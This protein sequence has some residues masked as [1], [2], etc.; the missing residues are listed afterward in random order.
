M[1]S[2]R[3]LIA[4]AA[5]A[6]AALMPSSASALPPHIIYEAEYRIDIHV[7]GSW[8]ISRAVTQGNKGAFEGEMNFS[9][10]TTL[11]DVV[12]RNGRLLNTQAMDRAEPPTVTG[13]GVSEEVRWDPEHNREYT[14]DGTCDA[15][16]FPDTSAYS[17]LKRRDGQSPDSPNEILEF[18]LIDS[19]PAG[20]VCTVGNEF[21]AGWNLAFNDH[22]FPNAGLDTVLTL[23]KEELSMGKIVAFARATPSQRS[24]GWCPYRDTWTRQCEF[25]WSARL[26]FT[27]VR[28]WQYGIEQLPPGM[29]DPREAGPVPGGAAPGAGSA[30]MPRT[31]PSGGGDRPATGTGTA[32]PSFGTGGVRLRGRELRFVAGCQTGC[33]GVAVITRPRSRRPLARVRFAVPAG[34]PREV[35]VRLP[36]KARRALARTRRAK[37]KLTLTPVRG[38]KAVSKT[39]ALRP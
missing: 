21:A 5:L 26:E 33:K 14:V 9:F 18:R 15:R 29:H 17:L 37:V 19:L 16:G 25:D 31:T 39:L 24:P 22:S 36:A 32:A 6:A 28:D 35:R 13:T 4:A 7:T 3:L 34:R 30:G 38:G 27:K 20:W 1:P 2:L 10:D 23:T 11:T 12:F 8:S